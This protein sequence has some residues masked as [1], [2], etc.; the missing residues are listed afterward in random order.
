MSFP[1]PNSVTGWL[2]LAA[3]A[4]LASSLTAFDFFKDEEGFAITWERGEINMAVGFDNSRVLSDGKT[5][6][7]VFNDAAGDWNAVLANVQFDVLGV[8]HEFISVE[9]GINGAAF[10]ESVMGESFGPNAVAVT[11]SR[12]DLSQTN[13]WRYSD[14]FYNASLSW[15]SY[16]G[17]LREELD[18]RRVT[19]RQL[20]YLLGLASPDLADPSQTIDAIMNS[21]IS[22]T[23]ELQPDDIA[24]GQFLYGVPGA[25]PG[26]DNFA[27]A[28]EIVLNGEALTDVTVV[29]GST[30]QASAEVGEPHLNDR[31]DES[32]K[33]VWWKWT[34]TS[35][36]DF[37]IT[38]AGSNFDTLLGVFTGNALNSIALFRSNDDARPGAIRTSEV[39]FPVLAGISY[40]IAVDGRSGYEGRVQLNVGYANPPGPVLNIA[41]SRILGDLGNSVTMVVEGIAAS[42]GA[43]SYQWFQDTRIIPGETS[44]SLRIDAFSNL[45]AGVYKVAVTESSGGTSHG[46][47]WVVPDY[48]ATEVWQLAPRADPTR[49]PEDITAISDIVQV[50][51]GD[52][53][54][55][56]LRR[57]GS[58][59]TWPVHDSIQYPEVLAV[60]EGLTN[61][62][63]VNAGHSHV[64]ALKS[65]GTV[66][67]WG[68]PE[69]GRTNVPP[70]LFGVV[71]VAAGLSHSLVRKS[72]GS[73]V[74]WGELGSDVPA[75]FPEGLGS[76]VSISTKRTTNLVGK[77]DGSLYSWGGDSDSYPILQSGIARAQAHNNGG[78]ALSQTG[79][80]LGWGDSSSSLREIPSAVIDV[81]AASSDVGLLRSNRE[82]SFYGRLTGWPPGSFEGFDSVLDADMGWDSATV[83]RDV[84]ANA[85]PPQGSDVRGPSR[86][87]EGNALELS[88]RPI[89]SPVM[90]HQWYK[91][92]APIIDGE[93]VTGTTTPT[94]R[95]EPI[96]LSDE[97]TYRLLS[98]NS[99]GSAFSANHEVAVDAVPTITSRPLTQ[100]VRVGGVAEFIV[101]ASGEGVVEY[102]WQKNGEALSGV[103]GNRL[104]LDPVTLDDRGRY[105]VVAR[106]PNGA[107]YS[108]FFVEV[109]SPGAEAVHWEDLNSGIVADLAKPHGG[110][111]K[112]IPSSSMTK[113]MGL[114]VD[115]KAFR[116]GDWGSEV[117]SWND[118]CELVDLIAFPNRDFAIG[119]RGDGTLVGAG[120]GFNTVA[121][122]EDLSEV[123]DLTGDGSRFVALRADGSVRPWLSS[124][125]DTF[126]P[127]PNRDIVSIGGFDVYLYMDGTTAG[128]GR[129]NFPTALKTPVSLHANLALLRSG[130]LVVGSID[131]EDHVPNLL[132]EVVRVQPGLAL[133]ANGELVSWQPSGPYAGPEEGFVPAAAEGAFEVATDYSRGN[134]RNYWALVPG[135][136]L[137]LVSAAAPTG[138]SEGGS[139]QLSVEVVSGEALS[140]QWY[141]DGTA[142]QDSARISGAQTSAI[143]IQDL[144]AADVGE[145]YVQV[146]GAAGTVESFRTPMEFLARPQITQQPASAALIVG[147]S[148]TLSVIGVASDSYQWN[149]NGLALPGA[150]SSSLELSDVTLED[151][152]TYSVELFNA[153]GSVISDGAV[154]TVERPPP[155]IAGTHQ[156]IADDRAP[157]GRVT[158][159]NQFTSDRSLTSLRWSVLLPDSW[160]L[161]EWTGPAATS[162]PLIG[163]QSLLEWSWT[164]APTIPF[165]FTYVL[166]APGGEGLNFQLGASFE[167]QGDGLDDSGL[168]LRDPLILRPGFHSADTS[169]DMRLG[170]S[171]LLRVIE[172]YNTRSGSSRTGR[173][174]L[175]AT[176]GDGFEPDSRDLAEGGLPPRHHSADTNQDGQLSLSELLRVIEIYNTRAASTR[177][178]RY[179]IDP[180]TQDGFS[181]DP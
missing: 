130:E 85:I 91:G 145:Y 168:V 87:A 17:P 108:H 152:G 133:R 178:G 13:N 139:A 127:N 134:V 162:E 176:S 42:D 113:G 131:R 149:K 62:V 59:V 96:T 60:P 132:D 154:V 10:S 2:Y 40:Y 141:R 61:V 106:N 123:I 79:Q 181:P 26:N 151:A 177:T 35:T 37:S 34:A 25:P 63:R 148:H 117:E 126:V 98:R 28:S 14:I 30:V 68:N 180:T 89:G 84:T 22:D 76:V 174:K 120:I 67:S 97:G 19:L 56:G 1:R 86:V 164:S 102:E 99:A 70:D 157:G 173:Y 36:G 48:G 147:D 20:G 52:D 103:S 150:V 49:P 158:I 16:R 146:T 128:A 140:F 32:R 3:F 44:D 119:L 125:G 33:T 21:Q 50:T 122:P 110:F 160:S 74:T 66:V 90:T 15:D 144:G 121:L 69:K 77:T 129:G 65:D 142:L 111:A 72:D 94:L 179:R 166:A 169:R 153:V 5:F 75:R 39:R 114:G 64:L 51:M 54:G 161:A 4:L 171:E 137:A 12:E 6:V 167:V 71:E 43:L 24:G 104:T 159:S 165:E 8:P 101:S 29:T 138:L 53:F 136:G 143:S 31:F 82:L 80:V 41:E 163:D 124:N 7:E 156:V 95:I 27:D 45:D 18:F 118:L 155:V 170:L 175:N 83:L 112:I 73:V 109:A 88:S 57:D 92:S 135:D 100:L 107:A 9:D 38:T 172:L 46:L 105:T 115:G 81:F 78:I 55:V 116:W 58:V 47:F 11:V 23:D 93:R